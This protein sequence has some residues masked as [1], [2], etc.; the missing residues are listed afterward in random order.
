MVNKGR[1]DPALL[2]RAHDRQWAE[3]LDFGWG[4]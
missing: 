2:V 1:A 4:Q 3:D